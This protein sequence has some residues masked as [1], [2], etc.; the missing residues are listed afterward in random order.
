MAPDDWQ[1]PY[2]RYLPAESAAYRAAWGT[3][4]ATKL[5]QSAGP[6]RGKI[7]EI[8]AGSAYVNAIRPHLEELGATVT[9]P[10]HG[11]RQG[12]RLGWYGTLESDL[13]PLD[14]APARIEELVDRLRDESR[15]VPPERFR[16]DASAE[17]RRPGLYSWWVDAAGAGE[18]SAGVGFRVAIGLIYAG[19][20]GATRWP[21]G[22]QSGNTLYS[23]IV[24]MHLGSNHRLST[25]RHT[26]GSIL[27]VA[28]DTSS[29][30]QAALTGWMER[31]LRVNAVPVDNADELG[32]VEREVLR[33][34][35]PPLNLHGMSVSPLRRRLTE[36]RRRIAAPAAPSPR[37]PD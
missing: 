1:S 5:D 36:L 15:A 21:S 34:L 18:L 13:R 32:H 3:R 10:L 9:D 26:I 17:L 31:H 30:D 22:K 23:R 25:F 24:G 19:L 4:V 8:H 29:I 20:A 33:V 7:I 27:A 37:P 28:A 12:Q 14:R 2:E 11:L 6:L 16:R 35:D